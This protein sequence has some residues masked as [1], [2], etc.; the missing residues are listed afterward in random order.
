[1]T[2]MIGVTTDTGVN[3]I[4]ETEIGIGDNDEDDRG[5]PVC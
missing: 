3:R 2:R 5:S 1:M 4:I